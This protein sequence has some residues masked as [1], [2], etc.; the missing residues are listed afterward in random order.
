MTD[1]AERLLAQHGVTLLGEIKYLSMGHPPEREC[2][3]R[4]RAELSVIIAAVRREERLA[5]F[6]AVESLA[7][8]LAP[9]VLAAEKLGLTSETTRIASAATDLAKEWMAGRHDQ[10]ESDLADARQRGAAAAFLEVAREHYHNSW[11]AAFV[12]REMLDRGH[13]ADAETAKHIMWEHIEH[14]S[15][16]R[17]RAFGALHLDGGDLQPDEGRGDGSAAALTCRH[18]GHVGPMHAGGRCVECGGYQ[19]TALDDALDNGAEGSDDG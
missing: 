19:V 15:R 7:L 12:G 10:R 11:A 17:A 3:E 5:A 6:E 1:D 8:A 14:E 9:F 13:Q 2:A 16:W 18:C 4:M